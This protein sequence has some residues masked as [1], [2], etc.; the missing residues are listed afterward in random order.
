MDYLH[1][2]GMIPLHAA[3]SVTWQPLDNLHVAA[4]FGSQGQSLDTSSM[5]TSYLMG[6]YHIDPS[7]RVVRESQ[8][9]PGTLDR[10][11][12]QSAVLFS[13]RVPASP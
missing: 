3:G 10:H 7:C 6:L 5:H 1:R 11:F 13:L 9:V 2:N 12:F 8:P 4:L